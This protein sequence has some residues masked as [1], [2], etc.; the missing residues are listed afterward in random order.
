[1][2]YHIYV[3]TVEQQEQNNKP[4]IAFDY[5][6]NGKSVYTVENGTRDGNC[7]S[8]RR[9][10]NVDGLLSSSFC[11]LV[12]EHAS[13]ELRNVAQRQANV[14]NEKSFTWR[15]AVSIE[16]KNLLAPAKLPTEF[17]IKNK[18]S[19]LSC[20][21][22]CCLRQ[23]DWPE[24]E[25]NGIFN[26]KSVTRRTWNAHIFGWIEFISGS[27]LLNSAFLSHHQLPPSTSSS[28]L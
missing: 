11:L 21:F 2:H 17:S 27:I 10:G 4:S 25:R 5:G 24:W 19:F 20:G 9:S 16:L 26:G 8:Q 3:D 18:P 14:K 15:A 12:C 28:L 13:C 6:L 22:S 7:A 23:F 1:M